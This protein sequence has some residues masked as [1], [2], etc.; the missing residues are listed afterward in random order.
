MHEKA[1][2]KGIHGTPDTFYYESGNFH[3]DYFLT[4]PNGKVSEIPTDA[5]T[6]RLRK[7]TTVNLGHS[8]KIFEIIKCI[9]SGGFSKVFLAR[10]Y[11]MLMAI[12]VI[13]KKII[14]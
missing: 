10:A 1:T 13:P 6:L 12:K 14:V 7:L 4:I 11:G 5:I 2:A 9:G 3:L 8:L